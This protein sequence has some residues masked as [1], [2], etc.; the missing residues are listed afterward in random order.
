MVG[1][2]GPSQAPGVRRVGFTDRYD[3]LSVDSGDADAQRLGA[4]LRDADVSNAWFL[5]DRAMPAGWQEVCL[6][7]G[8]PTHRCPGLQEAIGS[9]SGGAATLSAAA[10]ADVDALSC[11]MSARA[12]G[13]TALVYIGPELQIMDHFLTPVTGPWAMPTGTPEEKEE[14]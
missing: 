11:A 13:H 3:V 4:A 12:G 14:K 10:L 5:D 7:Y 1:G 6:T 2:S 9:V 8:L